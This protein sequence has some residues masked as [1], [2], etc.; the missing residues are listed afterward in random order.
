MQLVGDVLILCGH[1]LLRPEAL[2]SC[3]QAQ[4][5]VHEQLV[6]RFDI[7]VDVLKIVLAIG[8]ALVELAAATCFRARSVGHVAALEGDGCASVVVI[9]FALRVAGAALVAGGTS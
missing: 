2:H 3:S 4:R 8:N 7:D 5:A 1:R 9:T 6:P